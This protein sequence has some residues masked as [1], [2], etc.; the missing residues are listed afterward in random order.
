MIFLT[1]EKI[2]KLIFQR[3]HNQKQ[4]KNESQQLTVTLK[5][6]DIIQTTKLN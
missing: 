3:Q 6:S 5:R 4:Q 2:I 1:H